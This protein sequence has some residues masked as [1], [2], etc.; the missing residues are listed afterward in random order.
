MPTENKPGEEVE[1]FSEKN[2]AKKELSKELLEQEIEELKVA[3]EI[4]AVIFD[5]IGQI[6]RDIINAVMSSLDGRKL[7]QEIAEFYQMLKS[8]GLPDKVVEEMVVDFYKRKLE[9]VPSLNELLKAV[10]TAVSEKLGTTK[11]ESVK[12]RESKQSDSINQ[13]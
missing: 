4:V 3:K 2:V 13:H 6:A 10:S 5:K 8:S 7:G 9:L 11:A 1:G 12:S